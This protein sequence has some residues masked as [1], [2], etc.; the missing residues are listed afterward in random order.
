MICAR[1]NNVPSKAT[2]ES[3]E[4]AAYYLKYWFDSMEVQGRVK[5]QITMSDPAEA[6]RILSMIKYKDS[7]DWGRLVMPWKEFEFA[8]IKF[9]IGDEQDRRNKVIEGEHE[10]LELTYEQIDARDK[11]IADAA[12]D[13]ALNAGIDY[14]KKIVD[15]ED[16]EKLRAFEVYAALNSLRAKPR[17]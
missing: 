11:I 14:V 4:R 10:I 17:T 9:S 7:L 2:Q 13:G 15:G 12:W 16:F 6:D 5:L 3:F 1:R 8:G